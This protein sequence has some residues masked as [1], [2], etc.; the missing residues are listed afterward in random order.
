MVVVRHGHMDCMIHRFCDWGKDLRQ[1]IVDEG[2]A[3]CHVMNCL[4]GHGH[5]WVLLLGEGKPGIGL[6]IVKT[7]S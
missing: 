4:D 6:E 2:D 5:V 7:N 1:D 3:L